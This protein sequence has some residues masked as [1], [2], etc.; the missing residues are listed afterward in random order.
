MKV[1]LTGASG[2]LGSRILRQMESSDI[3]VRKFD[4][5]V[6][7]PDRVDS[8]VRGQDAVVHTAAVVP[9]ASVEDSPSQA[10]AVNVGG[11]AEV[12]RAAYSH[13]VRLVYVSSSHVYA[14]SFEPIREDFPCE[15]PSR[16]GLSKL[17]GEQWVRSYVPDALVVRCFSF[18]DAHQPATYLA[19][20]LRL[21]VH[22]APPGG[23]LPLQGSRSIRDFADATYMADVITRLTLD[24]KSGTVNC[25]TGQATSV[26]ELALLVAE[27]AGR[28]DVTFAAEAEQAADRVVA[29]TAH[30]ES[31]LGSAPA[32]DLRRAMQRALEAA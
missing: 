26:L 4:G 19:G 28:G 17:Q 29:D 24:G 11:T 10:I 8:F 22:E 21:R 30:L 25:G 27:L 20:A 18:F 23:V 15:P 14:P 31:L 12:A 16:Y 1:G 6:R 13:A 32:F 9:V 7:D 5:D 3:E 2:V